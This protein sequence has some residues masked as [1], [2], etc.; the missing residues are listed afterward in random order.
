MSSE[1]Q[2]V[3]QMMYQ[4]KNKD[5]IFEM[6]DNQI[7]KY[8]QDYYYLDAFVLLK[9]ME[10]QIVLKISYTIQF[11][12]IEFALSQLADEEFEIFE[13]YIIKKQDIFRIAE[14]HSMSIRSVYRI[15]DKVVKKFML[16]VRRKINE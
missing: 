2:E 16:K 9:K 14:L 1:I 6:I 4:Y 11:E 7:K 13:E 12:S 5:K 8:T 3:A 15:L 10:E